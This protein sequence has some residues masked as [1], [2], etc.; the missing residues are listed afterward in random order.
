STSLSASFVLDESVAPGLRT[1]R[2]RT[3]GGTSDPIT[4]TITRPEPGVP[5]PTLTTVAP[6]QGVRGSTV[7]VALTG[8]NFVVGATTVA[9]AGGG[10]TV[11]TV[12][13]GSTTSLTANFAL[14]LAAAAGART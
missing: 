14:D 11:N 4:F 13:V 10:V 6:N 5:A 7:A 3:A 1:V 12:V 8:T 9:V 2:V